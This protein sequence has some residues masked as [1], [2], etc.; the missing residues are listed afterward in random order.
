MDCDSGQLC[1]SLTFWTD[2]PVLIHDDCHVLY[3]YLIQGFR[4]ESINVQLRPPY[5][6]K[7]GGGCSVHSMSAYVELF[8]DSSRNDLPIQELVYILRGLAAEPCWYN[9]CG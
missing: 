6:V 8:P 3:T 2:V 4:G 5:D 9:P 7:A 1:C